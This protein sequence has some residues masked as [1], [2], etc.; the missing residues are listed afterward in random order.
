[1]AKFT[2]TVTENETIEHAYHIIKENN[3]SLLPVVD[4]NNKL[5]GVVSL[6]DII[7]SLLNQEKAN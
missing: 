1:M 4:K 6:F 2:I 3:L 7:F 5:V